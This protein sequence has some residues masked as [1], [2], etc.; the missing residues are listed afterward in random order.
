MALIEVTR[1]VKKYNIHPVRHP[2]NT[3]VRLENQNKINIILFDHKINISK[4]FD[5]KIVLVYDVYDDEEQLR[6][7]CISENYY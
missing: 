5:I 1:K 4:K 6:L 7:P 3:Y 2:S